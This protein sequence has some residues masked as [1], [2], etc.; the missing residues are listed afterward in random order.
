[1]KKAT[2]TTKA[3]MGVLP[4]VTTFNNVLSLIYSCNQISIIY[5][6][7]EDRQQCTTYSIDNVLSIIS[8]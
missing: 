6:D 5:M 8:I 7:N 1:M 3:P 4:H 2:V